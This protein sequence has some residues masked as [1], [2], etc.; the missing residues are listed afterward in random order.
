M[1]VEF[2]FIQVFGGIFL[3]NDRNVFDFYIKKNI[4]VIKDVSLV[5][6]IIIF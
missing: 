5:R 1:G 6:N 4:D 3:F 2:G